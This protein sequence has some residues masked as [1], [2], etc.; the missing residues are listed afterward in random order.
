MNLAM[1][2][3][4]QLKLAAFCSCELKKP[5]VTPPFLQEMGGDFHTGCLKD[6]ECKQIEDKMV[7]E[8]V[9]DA[10][11]TLLMLPKS[12]GAFCFQLQEG[13]DFTKSLPVLNS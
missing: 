13:L 4:H 9:N 3:G 10:A 11:N 6:E 7:D 8:L 1:V 2:L 12:I 5:L